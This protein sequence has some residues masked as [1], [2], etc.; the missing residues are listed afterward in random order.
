MA[1]QSKLEAWQTI[2]AFKIA[3]KRWR[4]RFYQVQ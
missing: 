1:R 3:V 4:K 2:M